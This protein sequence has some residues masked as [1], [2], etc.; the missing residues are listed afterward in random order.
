MR[1]G[2]LAP[3]HCPTMPPHRQSAPIHF[4]DAQCI[5]HCE[6]VAAEPL[7]RIGSLR[8]A[9]LAVTTPVVTHQP[10]MAAP[11]RHLVVPHVQIGVRDPHVP[12]KSTTCVGFASQ[13]T[14]LGS[15]W[16]A[17]Q[18]DGEAA[19]LLLRSRAPERGNLD[20]HGAPDMLGQIGRQC[21]EAGAEPAPVH[22][23][24]GLESIS[25]SGAPSGTR[26]CRH[27]LT[28]LKG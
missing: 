26:D 19:E 5:D 24:L 18:R 12:E 20:R 3:S 14:G 22:Q 16:E 9:R 13:K 10:E 21:L 2:A 11:G 17:A 23:G 7:H 4:A 15:T 6:H 25:L 27:A 8:H 1:P 28:L